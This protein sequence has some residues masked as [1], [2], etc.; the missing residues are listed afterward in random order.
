MHNMPPFSLLVKPASTNCN[1]RCRYCFYRD[2]GTSHP[3]PVRRR[4][5][6]ATLDRLIAGY[7]ANAQPIHTFCWQGGEPTLM[8]VRFFRRAVELQVAYAQP[9]TQI[10]NGLQTN[11]TLLDDE[12][13]AFLGEYRFLV[14]VSLDGPAA[15]HDSERR[16]P[17]G[18]ASHATVLSGIDCLRRNRVEFNILTLVNRANVSKPVEVYNYLVEQGFLYHQYIECVEFA[19]DGTLQQFA[20]TGPEWGDFLCQL[21]DRWYPRDTHRVSVR[22][23]DMVLAKIVDGVANTCTS[24]EDC[25]KYFVVEYNGDIYPCDFYVKQSRKLGNIMTDNWA[26]LW[27]SSAYAAFGEQ[28]RK[29]NAM[30]VSCPFLQ[31]C[32][33][34]CTKNRGGP[35][36]PAPTRLSH[37]CEGWRRFYRHTLPRFQEL[38]EQIRHERRLAALKANASAFPDMP[39]KS[40]LPVRPRRNDPC[41]CGRGRKFKHCCGASKQ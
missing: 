12:F 32:M 37:L 27:E 28:K 21:F 8:G 33:G 13:A 19:S 22:L 29:W 2:V 31:F 16:T 36:N 15:V 25:R 18:Q 20:I 9:G 7:M 40:V 23:F 24:S 30:C 34:D 41:P 10:A 26:S 14:G 3:E 38:A 1:L 5:D 39:A 6:D 4:M 35:E 11:G 17:G